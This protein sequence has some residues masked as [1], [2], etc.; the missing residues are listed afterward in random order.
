M[1]VYRISFLIPTL[2][3]QN[4][5][6]AYLS[7]DKQHLVN[8]EIQEILGKNAIRNVSDTSG[9]FLSNL[10]LVVTKNGG[11]TQTI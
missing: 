10:F 9:W 6:G 4:P 7:Q 5:K 3:T 8:Q 11:I 1:E 2:Q